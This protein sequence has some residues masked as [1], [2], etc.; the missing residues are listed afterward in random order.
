MY[1]ST[2]DEGDGNPS[3]RERARNVAKES[4]VQQAELAQ[5]R[6]LAHRRMERHEVLEIER[7]F[8]VLDNVQEGDLRPVKNNRSKTKPQLNPSHNPYIDNEADEARQSDSDLA[9][10]ESFDSG[11]SL[12][13]SDA[14]MG[15]L[16][17]LDILSYTTDNE[18]LVYGSDESISTQEFPTLYE[19]YSAS[20]QLME[21]Q[22]Q[23][24][25]KEKAGS[26]RYSSDDS[27]QH[28]DSASGDEDTEDDS[29]QQVYSTDSDSETDMEFEAS[30]SGVL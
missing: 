22:I 20:R 15:G 18:A 14:T 17:N 28:T 30:F 23:R 3:L 12:S 9:E 16:A 8:A 25:Q 13:D 19:N 4:A 5:A 6:R 10:E 29:D 7:A 11:T 24:E 1:L 26:S 27:N 2:D 21:A